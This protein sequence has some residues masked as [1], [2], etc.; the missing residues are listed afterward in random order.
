MGAEQLHI[1]GADARCAMLDSWHWHARLVIALL[2]N[3]VSYNTYACVGISPHKIYQNKSIA[4]VASKHPEWSLAQ[5]RAVARRQFNNASMS[6]LLATL[7]AVKAIRPK[8]RWGFYNFPIRMHGP[9]Q[10]LD[11]GTQ[12]CGYDHPEYG[13]PLRALNDELAALI[14]ASDLVLPSLYTPPNLTNAEVWAYTINNVKEAVRLR[15]TYNRHAEVLPFYG[16]YYH[17]QFGP[18]DPQPQFA[19][20]KDRSMG[21]PY[22][23]SYG[24]CQSTFY[25]L[26]CPTQVNVTLDAMAA[27][28]ADGMVAWA[29]GQAPYMNPTRYPGCLKSFMDYLSTALGPK[30]KELVQAE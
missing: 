2:R 8:A 13:P 6:F 12:L 30:V 7:S 23:C 25:K 10:S 28:G 14:Q 29:G 27:A 15:D 24:S 26:I 19:K 5:L 21:P 1:L 20:Q 11:N 4:E 22:Q 9:C 18:F 16:H 3:H 17:G